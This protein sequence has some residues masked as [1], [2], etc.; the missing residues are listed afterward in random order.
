MN[1]KVWK[2]KIVQGIVGKTDERDIGWRDAMVISDLEVEPAVLVEELI[3]FLEREENE[4]LTDP[5]Y[6][7]ASKTL[8]Q[9]NAPRALIECSLE[10]KL[11][12]IRNLKRH[13]KNLSEAKK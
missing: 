9:V 10:T 4:V 6:F 2:P 8:V 1:E 7:E 5:L 13:L 3:E 11:A 12:Y